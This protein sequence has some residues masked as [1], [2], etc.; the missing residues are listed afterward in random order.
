M[1]LPESIRG[2]LNRLP[3]GPP[4]IVVAVSGGAD[5]VALLRALVALE[6]R[7]LVIAHLNHR[8][9][10][11]ESD[12]DEQFVRDLHARSSEVQL[13]VRRADVGRIATEAGEN[14]EATARRERYRFLAD[15]AGEHGI[16]CIATAH[17]A[18]DQAETVLHRL[19]R[20]T[21]LQGL[22]G[23]AAR[24]RLQPGVELVRPMLDISRAEILAYLAE[25]NQPYREDRSNFDVRFTRNRIRH[26]LL[27]LLESSYNPNVAAQLCGVAKQATESFVDV[28]RRARRLLSAC[29]LPPAGPMRILDSERLSAAPRDLRREALRLL[30]HR[31][32]WP[33]SRMRFTEW[34]R[35][36]AVA[37][38][39][40]T[41][42]D[43][44]GRLHAR[45]RGRVL[46][47]GP[48]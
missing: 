12:A 5:S 39:E 29:E 26:E 40:L 43:L 23:I 16:G 42:V 41:A 6:I 35:V 38:G 14:L 37:A 21:G 15:V 4:G 45:R 18:N 13:A 25:I 22:R 2:F 10:G 9:R 19:I 36:A 34:D 24:R 30:W 7:P 48:T 17:T 28:R 8:L 46:Q 44:P 33:L 1:P 3:S 32:A 31:E 20:G 27:P 11:V 47:I